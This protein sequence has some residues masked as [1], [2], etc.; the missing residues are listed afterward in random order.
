[1]QARLRYDVR[2]I[3]VQN[4]NS[5]RNRSDFKHFQPM[6]CDL[7]FPEKALSVLEKSNIRPHFSTKKT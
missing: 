1:M 4:Y 7:R 3:M 2:R 5:T 6:E